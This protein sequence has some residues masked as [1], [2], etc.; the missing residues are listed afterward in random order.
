MEQI[1]SQLLSQWNLSIQPELKIIVCQSCHSGVF[2]TEIV[3]HLRGH[4]ITI[5]SQDIEGALKDAKW[6]QVNHDALDGY[7]RDVTW[8]KKP[9]VEGIL[10][11]DGFCCQHCP[12]YCVGAE[13]LRVHISTKHHDIKDKLPGSLSKV[14]SIYSG[15]RRLFFG[16]L[17]SASINAQVSLSELVKSRVLGYV[18][19]KK[20]EVAV[21][22]R[23]SNWLELIDAAGAEAL[24][25]LSQV[26]IDPALKCLVLEYIA[27]TKDSNPSTAFLKAVQDSK[28]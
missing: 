6:M 3:G 14:Q 5:K 12:Y 8:I 1:E 26:T 13:T 2:P 20:N 25:T 9:A 10:I 17:L 16:V 24:S 18:E 27:Q 11:K 15:T 28:G 23:V 19:S 4:D 7:T 21:F 22:Y